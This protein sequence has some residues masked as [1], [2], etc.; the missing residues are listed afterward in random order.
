MASRKHWNEDGLSRLN[1]HLLWMIKKSKTF[2]GFF[3]SIEPT[4]R[5]NTSMSLRHPS[6]GLWLLQAD[7]FQ[8]WLRKDTKRLWLSGIPGAG[9]TVLASAIIEEAE[10]YVN[11]SSKAVSYYYCDYKDEKSQDPVNILGSLV[12]QLAQQNPDSFDLLRQYYRHCNPKSKAPVS[13]DVPGLIDVIRK[14]G[15][16]FE[17]VSVIVD[18]LDECGKKTAYLTKTLAGMCS[19][20]GAENNLKIVLLSRD[21]EEIRQCLAPNFTHLRIAAQSGDLELYVAAEIDKRMKDGRLGIRNLKLKEEVMERLVKDADGMFRWVTCQLDYLCELPHDRARRK[22]L[23]CLPP[24]LNST[25]ERI[26][27]RVNNQNQQVRSLVRSTLRW[28]IHAK[29]RLSVDALCEALSIEDDLNFL[30]PDGR[31]TAQ[32]LLMYCSSLLRVSVDGEYL[33]LAHFTVEEYLTKGILESAADDPDIMSYIVRPAES[34]MELARTCLLYLNLQDFKQDVAKDIEEWFQIKEDF[35]FRMHAALY[36]PEYADSHWKDADIFGLAK[37]LFHPSKSKNFLTWAQDYCVNYAFSW[38][39]KF[40]ET[41]QNFTGFEETF[42]EVTAFSTSYGISTLHYSVFTKIL[43]LLLEKESPV[44][45]RLGCAIHPVHIAVAQRN[46]D[47]LQCLLEHYCR[48]I[49]NTSVTSNTSS[50]AASSR[51]TEDKKAGYRGEHSQAPNGDTS[52]DKEQNSFIVNIPIQYATSQG[53]WGLSDEIITEYKDQATPLHIAAWIDNYEAA[54]ILLQYGAEIDPQDKHLQTPLHYAAWRGSTLV[55]GLL[56]K[57]EANANARTDFNQTP[58]MLAVENGH[59]EILQELQIYAPQL[60]CV[61]QLGRN[62]VHY[63][64]KAEDAEILAYIL[65]MGIQHTKNVFGVFPLCYVFNDID[66]T[67]KLCLLLNNSETMA[68]ANHVD[69]IGVQLLIKNH[70]NSVL[71]KVLKKLP[72]YCGARK[73]INTQIG[74]AV[75]NPLCQAASVGDVKVMELLIDAGADIEAEGCDEGTP[76]MAACNSGRLS[77]VEFLIRRGAKEAYCKDGVVYDCIGTA[78]HF[79]EI[80]QWI[81]VGRYTQQRKIADDSGGNREQREFKPWSGLEQMEIPLTGNY[82]R[83]AEETTLDHVCRLQRMREDLAGEVLLWPEG[84]EY[85]FVGV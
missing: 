11:D 40:E 17:D 81:L 26:I 23:K 84:C 64:C 31:P 68:D 57:N 34:T 83:H 75:A 56:L 32:D 10:K 1:S 13:P 77:V 78:K 28:I 79:P 12:T 22:A 3:G 58:S 7:E 51:F 48:S 5:H 74:N 14:M 54:L 52:P 27:H 80:R 45:Y 67:A 69:S 49:R 73:T 16:V 18:A 25:Y 15:T 33:E 61:D 71:K 38:I 41:F 70:R 29:E 62:L 2:V 46:N 55:A 6:T 76:L 39:R 9:K 59:L 44:D 65:T 8:A 24:D 60:N 4:Q 35:P 42:Q 63:A 50:V 36:W 37:Q 72:E 85:P 47:G 21:E 30:D 19:T 20:I 43:R 66:V 53:P 82:G